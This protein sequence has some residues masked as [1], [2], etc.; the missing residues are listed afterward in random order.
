[1]E[2]QQQI[3][4]SFH[5]IDIIET[6]FNCLQPYNFE[7][8]VNL[9][10]EAKLINQSIKE[11]FR[12]L[13][14]VDLVVEKYFLFTVTA[15]GNFEFNGEIEEKKRHDLININAPAIMFPYIRSF[16]TTITA[17]FGNTLPALIIPPQFF[18]GDNLES[19]D[20]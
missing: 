11:N 2:L 12:L 13:M 8:K 19:I 20:L 14:K 4:L 1:M 7:E 6:K 18:K 5:G 16:I 10:V 3:M 9:D 15:I 17:N